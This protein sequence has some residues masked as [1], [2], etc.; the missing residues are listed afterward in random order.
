MKDRTK[1]NKDHSGENHPVLLSGFMNIPTFRLIPMKTINQIFLFITFICGWLFV[2]CDSN[3]FAKLEK[4]FM[5]PPD[6]ARPGVYWYFMDGNLS[7]EAMTKDLESMKKAGI[8]YL[9]YLEVNVGVPRGPVDFLSPEWKEL[10]KHAVEE[11]ERLGIAITLGV[12][13]G[14]TGSGGPWVQAEASMQ[15]LV[16]S[17]VEVT[18]AGKKTIQLPVPAP[19]RPF[20]GEGGFTPQVKKQW[21]EYYEDVVILA[22]P[23]PSQPEHII[24]P[25]EKA[26][27]YRAPYSSQPGVKPFLPTSA[28]YENTSPDGVIQKEKITDLTG[29]MKEDGSL[30]WDVPEGKWTIMRFSCRNNGAVTRPAPIPGVGLEADKFD[31]TALNAHLDYFTGELFRTIGK[32]NNRLPGGLKMLHMDSWEMGAQNWTS[33]FREEF[34]RRRKYDPQPFYPVY[35]GMIVGN[36]ETSERFLWDLRLTSQELILENHAGHIKE[37]GRRYGYGLSIEPYDMNP[38][39]DL[40]L[41]VTA[42]MPMCE[43]WSIGYGF[44]TSFSAMEGTSAAHLIG[45]PV[46]PAEAFTAHLDGWKQ[47]PG[48]MKDQSDWAFASGINRLV[49]HTFQHQSLDDHLRPGMTMGPYGVHWDRNQT[50][51]PMVD[52]YHRYVARCQLMLQQG[53]TVAD[54]LYLTPE[55]APHVFRAPESA[56]EYELPFLP[57][58]KGYN[59]DGCPPG[60]IEQASVKHHQIVFPGGASYSLLVLPDFETMTP[61][62]LKKIKELVNE[63]ATVI[64]LP[65]VKSPGLTN[66]PD[67]DREVQTIAAELWGGLDIPQTLTTRTFGKGKIIWGSELR[68]K[69]DLLYAPYSITSGVLSS[70]NI[71]EDFSA[72]APIRYTHRT[73]PDGDI[74]FVANRTGNKVSNACFFR[75]TGKQPELWDPITGETR[76]LPE[77]MAAEGGVKIQLEFE[78]HESY[79]IIFRKEGIPSNGKNFVP[80]QLLKTLD[81]KWEVSFDPAWGG[82]ES[83]IFEQLTDWTQHPDPGIRYY[84]GTAVYKQN[85]DLPEKNNG[86]IY[87]NLGKVKNMARVRING[88][89]AGTIWTTPWQVDITGMVRSKNNQ[90]EIEVVNLWPNRLIGDEQLPDDGIRNG[91]WPDWITKGTPRNSGRYTFSTYKH[92][93]KDSPLLE[94]G[95]MGPVTIWTS[96]E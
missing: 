4:E 3:S 2:S 65:P 52:A 84:S 66:Y 48:S 85:F 88:K 12:G 93:H 94:S 67:C 76:F 6:S 29:L 13:P 82:P 22:F 16:S 70:M 79:F 33:R 43:F 49:Y 40:E 61:G 14:W 26:L 19:K 36:R 57:D 63:G 51:W 60:M 39:A 25:D 23:T 8:G 92:Y 18:G 32:R 11:C 17:S 34:I 83:T 71:P 42:D 37:Y 95:L 62:L 10:F 80:K 20:F 47:H 96:L 75:I 72:K 1:R 55:G 45:Q 73:M 31:T 69:A 53:R 86:K 30:T 7:R 24:N 78:P 27:Y 35:A 41:A 91:Q 77:Y 50:W 38:T 15:H 81:S 68:E 74:Y 21:E 54:V 89:E 58:R 46:V 9:V 44:N 64:G 87:L 59:F 5:Y 90:L 28:N 56:L